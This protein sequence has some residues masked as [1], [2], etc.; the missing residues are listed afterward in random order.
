[1]EVNSHNKLELHYY[2]SDQSH[3]ID[4]SIRN[5]CESEIL[6]IVNEAASIFDISIKLLTEPPIEGG[7]RDI[8]KAIGD[9]SNQLQVL[10]VAIGVVTT[11]YFNYT[12]E[13]DERKKTLEELQ[14]QE[15]KH[16]LKGVNGATAEEKFEIA[17]AVAIKLSKNLKII[18]R[19]SNF[20]SHLSHYP[21]VSS[22]SL[23]AINE[24]T[25]MTI[26]ETQVSRQAFYKFILSTNKLKVM[27]DHT[28]EIEIIS[29]VLKDGNYKWKGVYKEQVIS[30]N[31]TD[32]KFRDSIFIDG[33]N[34]HAG[35]SIKCL[36]QV[37]RELDEVGE[38]KIK[39]YSVPTVIE[40]LD[41]STVHKTK[42]GKAYLHAK[43]MIDGQEDLF[44]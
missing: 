35:T 26:K 43:A 31:M 37:H 7:F 11:V 36:L 22:I 17:N 4:A 23:N 13:V 8:W 33:F 5:E 20:Y 2:F 1:M 24:Q 3:D 12:P 30:F 10:L 28:A 41:G 15:L 16:R 19:K 34:F 29:P 44:V 42:Q 18:K 39:G 21:K 25:V 38:I 40:I 27:E 14:I 6:A 32:N 9:N